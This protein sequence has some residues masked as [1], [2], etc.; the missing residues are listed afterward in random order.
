MGVRYLY[1]LHSH[2]YSHICPFFLPSSFFDNS[3]EPQGKWK[4]IWGLIELDM[5]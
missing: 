2:I 4:L 1:R 5:F 3:G